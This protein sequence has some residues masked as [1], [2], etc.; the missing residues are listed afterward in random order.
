VIVSHEQRD[1]ALFELQRTMRRLAT[2][3]L[4]ETD[5]RDVARMIAANA[6]IADQGV[7][8][9]ASNLAYRE[10]AGLGARSWRDEFAAAPPAAGRLKELAERYFKPASWISVVVGPPPR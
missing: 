3:E 6:A 1:D 2:D 9:L 10:A 7:L 5:R 8:P 4:G